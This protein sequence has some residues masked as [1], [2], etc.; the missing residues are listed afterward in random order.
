MNGIEVAKTAIENEMELLLVSTV[1]TRYV[2]QTVEINIATLMKRPRK[3]RLLD[4]DDGRLTST[5]ISLAVKCT[6]RQP[7]AR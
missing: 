3:W 2:I 7:K 4:D 5:G 6:F 1:M